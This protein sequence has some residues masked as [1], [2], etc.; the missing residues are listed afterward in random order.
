MN[1]P[2]VSVIVPCYNYGRFIAETIQSI[3]R[4]TYNNWECIVVDDGSTDNTAEVVKPFV[5]QDKRVIYIYQE[6]KGLPAARNT[7]IAASKGD[8]FQWLDSDDLLQPEKLSRQVA[9]FQADESLDIVYSGLRYFFTDKPQELIFSAQFNRPWTLTASGEGLYILYFLIISCSIMPP[10][11]LIRR[12]VIDRLGGFAFGF[13]G[14]EDWE[15]WLRCAYNEFKFLYLDTPQ[16][17][18]LMRIHSNNMTKGRLKM[19]GGFVH[20]RTLLHE[21]WALKAEHQRLNRRLLPHEHIELALVKQQFE[22]RQA[23]KTYFREQIKKI[24]GLRLR[25]FFMLSFLFPPAFNIKLLNYLR[26]IYK[27]W[28]YRKYKK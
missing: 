25:L 28:Y 20:L 4:Q 24:G 22:S 15:F 17:L 14:V 16:T 9:A 1:Q 19:V 12:K 10:M 21:S 23:S 8:F 27:K 6:N 7:G 2:L 13:N 18:S 3:Q 11:P 5:E 26:A